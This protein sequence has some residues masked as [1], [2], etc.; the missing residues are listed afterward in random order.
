[1]RFKKGATDN[2]KVEDGG[3]YPKRV[4]KVID[5]FEIPYPSGG[6]FEL[7]EIIA[8]ARH[9]WNYPTILDHFMG[10]EINKSRI[11]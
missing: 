10:T 1:V 3:Q 8:I 2:W 5:R 4:R 7:R 6:D 9:L 11:N